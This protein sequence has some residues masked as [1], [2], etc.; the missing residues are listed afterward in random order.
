VEPLNGYAAGIELNFGCDA[1]FYAHFSADG[2]GEST[3]D[4]LLPANVSAKHVLQ[5]AEAQIG[6]LP[7]APPPTAARARWR[8]AGWRRTSTT[9]STC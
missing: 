4:P 9:A 5:G 3:A 2:T 1:P 8:T 7:R 6:F